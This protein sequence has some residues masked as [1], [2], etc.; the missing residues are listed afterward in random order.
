MVIF[1]ANPASTFADLL[2]YLQPE[3]N[4]ELT[5]ELSSLLDRQPQTTNLLCT[6]L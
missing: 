3:F 2:F 6:R 5:S 1:L 4:V